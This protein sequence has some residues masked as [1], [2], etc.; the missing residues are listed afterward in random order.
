MNATSVRVT[1]AA[2]ESR[3]RR[4]TVRTLLSCAC[5]C[6]LPLIV[7]GAQGVTAAPVLADD[8]ATES[9]PSTPTTS[10]VTAAAGREQEASEDLPGPLALVRVV[11]DPGQFVV[12]GLEKGVVWLFSWSVD[13]MRE[14]MAS[15]CCQSLNF[16]TQTPPALSYASPSVRGLWGT[17]RAIANA[18]L[19]LAAAWGAFNVIVRGHLGSPYHEALDLFPRLALGAL[20]VNTSLWWTQLAVDANNALCGAVGQAGLP[21]W[22]R[23]GSVGQA[24][25]A[26][27]VTLVYLVMGL[28][29]LLQQLARLALVDVLLVLAPVGLLCWILPQTQNW[30]RLWSGT[31]FT[32]V[33]TQFAQV[34]TLRVGASLIGDYLT[35]GWGDAQILSLLLA[36]AVLAL[37]VKMPSLMRASVGGGMGFVRYYAYRTASTRLGLSAGRHTTRS[38]GTA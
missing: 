13:Q 15:L 1:A 3:V 25:V 14:A 23:V 7:L 36:I 16:V 33:F 24:A 4:S 17:V 34:A 11:Q 32:T 27:V 6:L 35:L 22:D 30:A 31:F 8:G 38:N 19:V 21:A 2:N 20:L 28:I 29:L 18:G 9:A 12:G 26:V 5:L 10:G 37:T